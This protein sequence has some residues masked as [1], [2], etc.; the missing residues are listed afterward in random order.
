MDRQK[1]EQNI[2][3]V[4]GEDYAPSVVSEKL[5]DAFTPAL[6]VEFDPEEA[7]QVGAFVEDALS[8][9][10]AMQSCCDGVHFFS[11][12]DEDSSGVSHHE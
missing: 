6:L 9:E 3:P 4:G 10:E 7:T 11:I 5:F 8:E 12:D 2:S 1:T